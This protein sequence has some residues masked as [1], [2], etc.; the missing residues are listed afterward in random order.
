MLRLAGQSL[1]ACAGAKAPRGAGWE[2]HS[3]WETGLGAWAPW[4]SA[5]SAC[6]QLEH[7]LLFSGERFSQFHL[8]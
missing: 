7:L 5:G 3:V 2:G 1:A 6:F 8:F 4:G